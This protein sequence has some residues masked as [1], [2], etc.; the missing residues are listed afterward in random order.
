[1]DADLGMGHSLASG[2]RAAQDW[3]YLFVALADMPWV[4]PATLARLRSAMERHSDGAAII[5]QPVV[6]GRP[7]HPVGFSRAFF[8]AL[9]QLRGDAGARAIVRAN[10]SAIVPLQVDDPGILRDLDTP[11]QAEAD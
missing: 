5:L 1:V 4:R 9:Q 7:G 10:P 11:D 2:A 3:D 6:D 8:S